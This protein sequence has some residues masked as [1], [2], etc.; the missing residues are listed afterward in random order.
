MIP[1]HLF[2]QLPVPQSV[3]N[4]SE[5]VDDFDAYLSILSELLSSFTSGFTR[6]AINCPPLESQRVAQRAN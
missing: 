6:S 2:D 1:P 5:R 4:V 3:I